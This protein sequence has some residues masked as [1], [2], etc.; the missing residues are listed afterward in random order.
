MLDL[1]GCINA[2]RD[3]W[4]AGTAAANN[5]QYNRNTTG[6]PPPHPTREA[7]EAAS[8]PVVTPLACSC[9]GRH[10]PGD[11]RKSRAKNTI[12]SMAVNGVVGNMDGAKPS[13]ILQRSVE[14]ESSFKWITPSG[15]S[16]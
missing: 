1:Q 15:E 3:G 7:I 9:K 5:V 14:H 13:K 4:I 10:G 16:L 6:A 11:V 2:A 8:S 12:K